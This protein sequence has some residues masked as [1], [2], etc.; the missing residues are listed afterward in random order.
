M[1]QRKKMCVYICRMYVYICTAE[2]VFIC[3]CNRLQ[4]NQILSQEKGI[5]VVKFIGF[6]KSKQRGNSEHFF[7][8]KSTAL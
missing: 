5:H 2:V 8:D 3:C 4:S 7:T 1:F 6:H